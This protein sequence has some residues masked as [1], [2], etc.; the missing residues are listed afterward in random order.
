MA[1]VIHLDEVSEVWIDEV[2]KDCGCVG[3]D[4]GK[5]VMCTDEDALLTMYV[6]WK[7]LKKVKSVLI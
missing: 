5:P 4:H 7:T 1:R 2:K 6:A 3:W